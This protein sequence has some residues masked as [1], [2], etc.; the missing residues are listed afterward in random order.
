MFFYDAGIVRELHGMPGGLRCDKGEPGERGDK[1][2]RGEKG[3]SGTPAEDKVIIHFVLLLILF[4]CRTVH[5]LMA[6]RESRMQSIHP[7]RVDQIICVVEVVGNA[8]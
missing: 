7:Q 2:E 4:H 6:V 3:E 1:G 8:I 5:Y